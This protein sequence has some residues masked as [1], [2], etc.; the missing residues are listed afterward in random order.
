MRLCY[1]HNSSDSFA[2]AI[3]NLINNFSTI[4][5]GKNGINA[6]K[7]QYNWEKQKHKLTNIYNK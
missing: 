4:N 1:T 5:Y 6:V 3:E 2:D 7:T